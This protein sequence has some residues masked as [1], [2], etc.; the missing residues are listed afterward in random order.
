MFDFY[1]EG[2]GIAWAQKRVK[3]LLFGFVFQRVLFMLR[4]APPEVRLLICRPGPGILYE[5]DDNT[6]VSLHTPEHIQV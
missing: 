3:S 6:L 4:G 5:V 2:V 1:G